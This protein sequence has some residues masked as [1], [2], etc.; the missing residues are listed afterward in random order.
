MQR[1][2]VWHRSERS[3]L[4][5]E[6]WQTK[7]Y[8]ILRCLREEGPCGGAADRLGPLPYLLMLANRT[9]RLLFIHWTHPAPLEAFLVP[10]P[11]GMNWTLPGAV[12]FT[13]WTTVNWRTP[14]HN[15]QIINQ[16][17][18]HIVLEP[19][20]EHEA[21][22]DHVVVE[23]RLFSYFGSFHD[24][25]ALNVYNEDQDL[26]AGEST[27]E[28]VY[29]EVWRVL[30]EPSLPVKARI[31]KAQ[32]SLGLSPGG[33]VSTHIRAQ[34]VG[35]RKL[36]MAEVR[37]ALHCALA[38]HPDP[39]TAV[40][41]ASDSKEAI[42][43]G[44]DYGRRVLNRTVIA[45]ADAMPPL[46]LDRGG[47][48]LRDGPDRNMHPP[49]AYYGTFVDLYLLSGGTCVALGRGGYGHW[50]SLIGGN[51]SCSVRH[52]A[53]EHDTPRKWSRRQA[54]GN[55]SCHGGFPARTRNFTRG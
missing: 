41:L 1:Y 21:S 26:A 30:F 37:N 5:P 32:E 51:P 16:N 50:A 31:E 47:Q 9:K 33:Y 15:R 36:N 3:K 38:L 34:Y 6:N 29:A 14:R 42:R 8:L 19:W 13:N 43:F 45:D 4:T 54:F 10:P 11:G 49:S 39:P 40:Y 27:F 12:N 22:T 24:R 48:F 28:Q 53:N 2:F 18:P 44:V 20:N 55:F 52:T 23:A 17:L 46:H 7:R 25:P 35:K